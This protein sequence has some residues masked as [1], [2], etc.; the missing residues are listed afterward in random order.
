MKKPIRAE[1]ERR[2]RDKL[3]EALP[4]TAEI[5]ASLDADKAAGITVDAP[6]T[7]RGCRTWREAWVY[8]FDHA[9]LLPDNFLKRDGDNI[10]C[11]VLPG[12]EFEDKLI[13]ALEKIAKR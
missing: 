13:D 4:E 12:P 5:F 3:I 2:M 9:C 7:Y 11:A 1:R 6:L 10:L 8:T